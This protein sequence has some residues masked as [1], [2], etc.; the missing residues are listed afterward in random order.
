MANTIK[1]ITDEGVFKTIKLSVLRKYVQ[2][3]F[4]EEEKDEIARR[5]SDETA[6]REYIVELYKKYIDEVIA[7]QEAENSNPTTDTA[8]GTSEEKT[9]SEKPAEDEVPASKTPEAIAKSDKHETAVAEEKK[10]EIS[11]DWNLTLVIRGV[12]NYNGTVSISC[13]K[14]LLLAMRNL[15]GQF[16]FK[17][18]ARCKQ[19]LNVLENVKTIKG[20]VLTSRRLMV[21]HKIPV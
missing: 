8:N 9:G 16:I 6:L 13:E 12:Q 4:T 19:F 2:H 10:D 1:K 7:E 15:K 5:A 20:I 17:S 18:K 11:V 3:K 14:L 21:L